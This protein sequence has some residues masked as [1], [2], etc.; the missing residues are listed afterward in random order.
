MATPLPNSWLVGRATKGSILH[1]PR[2][3]GHLA[4]VYVDLG[5]VPLDDNH[6]V[7]S[8]PIEE[9]IDR[10]NAIYHP[11]S[12]DVKNVAWH[13]VYEVGHRLTD[14]FDDVDTYSGE[15]QEI[16]KNLIDFD[17]E[18]ST[19]MA[20][21]PEDLPSPEYLE[22]FYVKTAEFPAGFMTEYKPSL[23][24]G[25]TEHQH[26]AEGFPVG[27]RFRSAR[28]NRRENAYPRHLGHAAVADGRY[29]LYVFADAAH[30]ASADSKVRAL[31]DFLT[32]DAT[33]PFVR[34]RTEG[35]DF[36]ALIEPV[37]VYQQNYTEFETTDAPAA[38][39]FDG[40][41][42]DPEI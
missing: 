1:I 17:K 35:A 6:A 13:S 24:T 3:G 18:W 41:F 23:I 11:Y 39:Y 4:R 9:I 21:K 8:T 42:I 28:V 27:K 30:P 31:S 12:I 29:R 38:F 40:V 10:A 26:L 33:S 20:T 7:R 2:E 37:V 5:E 32:Q 14:H 19:L 16:A 22:E 34:Y 15:R 36:N 25:S